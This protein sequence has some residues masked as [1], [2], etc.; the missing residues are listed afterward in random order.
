LESPFL[1]NHGFLIQA[2]AGAIEVGR[3]INF[4][5][6]SAIAKQHLDGFEH[7]GTLSADE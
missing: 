4:A 3:H 6:C 5:A 2:R 7:D 1:P